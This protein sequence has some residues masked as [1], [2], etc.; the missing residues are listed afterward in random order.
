MA[1][2][3]K[4]ERKADLLEAV[5][6]RELIGLDVEGGSC[7]GFNGTATRIWQ[8]LEEPKSL[9]ELRD[10]LMEEYEVEPAA[11]EEDLLLFLRA[12]ARDGL[13]ALPRGMAEPG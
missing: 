12:M 10:L 1:E 6:D 5:V 13:I 4:I 11:C 2:Q 8:L 7:F 3:T 9:D